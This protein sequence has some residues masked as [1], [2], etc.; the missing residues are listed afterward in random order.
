MRRSTKDFLPLIMKIV[1]V[2]EFYSPKGGGVRTYID[3]K[4]AAG[5][6]Y[7]H[8][9]VIV[10]PGPKN[11]EESRPG[12]R[13]VWVKSPRLPVD[14]R[15]HML[16]SEKSVHQILD[17]EQADVVEGSSPWKGG[18][19]VARW[20]G[21]SKKFLFWHQEPV[22]A[23][24]QAL[25]APMLGAQRVDQLF[26]GHWSRLRRLEA[27]F[28]ASVVSSQW[29]AKRLTQFGLRAPK[30]I[31]LGVEENRF[32][33]KHR[34]AQLRS[35]LLALCGVAGDGI[36]L[37]AVTR[38]HPEKFVGTVID[39]FSRAK[40]RR[41]MGL[42]LVG[43]GPL[44]PWVAWLAKRAG[45]VTLA[46]VISDRDILAQYMAS[47][48]I[49]LHG[50]SAEPYGLVV[51]EAISSGLPIVVPDDGGAAELATPEYA[52][53]YRSR[54]PDSAAAAILRMAGRDREKMSEICSRVSADTIGTMEN[55]FRALF[56]YYAAY[57]NRRDGI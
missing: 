49:F 56:S 30:V 48:D 29:L 6:R 4:L 31:P 11:F 16:T 7:G 26:A 14:W 25:L 35:E 43:D 23:Y 38:F 55:H 18:Q 28:D 27:Q 51:A 44:R 15:Y 12:G 1:D 40:R 22:S 32:S 24:P 5:A 20:R 41:K 8:E 9:I 34:S 57:D 42:V 50:G 45:S 19:I 13:I 33:S 39:A 10:A 2:A 47:A 52:E 46:G 36:L 17:A 21:P 54:D 37:L 3:R 53:I